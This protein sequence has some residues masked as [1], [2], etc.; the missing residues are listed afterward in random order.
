MSDLRGGTPKRQAVDAKELD[1]CERQVDEVIIPVG[2]VEEV[3]IHDLHEV[4]C[5]D[6]VAYKE[7]QMKRFCWSEKP[8][9]KGLDHKKFKMEAWETIAQLVKKVD[10][11]F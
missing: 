8:N 11:A 1:W 9:N 2:T 3:C 5:N 6:V 7:G 4:A 10:W